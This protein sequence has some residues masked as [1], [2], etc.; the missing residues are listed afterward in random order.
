MVAKLCV[1][2]LCLPVAFLSGCGGSQT[3]SHLDASAVTGGSGGSVGTG[4][5]PGGVGGGGIGGQLTTSAA[6]NTCIPGAAIACA[7]VTGQAGAQTCTS[8]GV[9]GACVCAASTVDAGRAGRSDGAVTSPPDAAAVGGGGDSAGSSGAT[10]M[11]GT[12][13]AG[14]TVAS[15]GIAGS[16]GVVGTGGIGTGGAV[17]TG[18]TSAVCQGSAT[19]CS[20]DGVQTCTNGQWGA[21]ITCSTGLI[22]E[23]C[24]PAACADP[25]WVEWPMPNSQAD[26]TAGAPNLESYTDNGDGTVTDTVTGLMWQKAVSATATY[27]LAQAVAYCP[28][29]TLAGH[30]DWRLPSLVELFSIVDAGQSNPSINGTYFPSTPANW[31]WSSSPVAGSPSYPWVVDFYLGGAGSSDFSD[32]DYVRCVR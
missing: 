28:T 9:F 32:I 29:L 7:C 19:Q 1:A 14:G 11:G 23:R 6:V 31:F 4:G 24:V 13:G 10:S 16:G 3:T 12:V 2:V 26:V 18:G 30:S 8:A 27:T 20:G 15:G 22:C 21:A 17:G 25:N 5:G